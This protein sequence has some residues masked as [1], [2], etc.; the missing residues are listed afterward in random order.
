MSKNSTV[1]IGCKMPNGLL[2]DFGVRGA[3]GFKQVK[4]NG[5]NEGEMREGGLFVAKT[6]AGFGRTVLDAAMWDAW[7]SGADIQG[8]EILNQRTGEVRVKASDV[9]TRLIAARKA[10]IADWQEK[11][12]LFVVD[13]I[14]LAA[15]QANEKAASKSG[16]EP[17]A[18][19]GDPRAPRVIEKVA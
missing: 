13:D 5:A 12:L 3:P 11:G 8:E 9:R 19:V 15:A 14:D 17:L 7:A 4:I 18:Q 16:F 2:L 1:V 10:Q 6:V